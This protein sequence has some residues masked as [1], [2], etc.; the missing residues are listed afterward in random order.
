[1]IV[2]GIELERALR[3][4]LQVFGVAWMQSRFRALTRRAGTP[5][6]E[7]HTE[8][9]DRLVAPLVVAADG[10]DSSVRAAAGLSLR[11][12]DYDATGLVIHLNSSLAHQGTAL[13]WFAAHGVLAL[14][15]MPDTADGHQVSMVWSMPREQAAGL[16]AATE[17][18]RNTRLQSLLA[19][20][21]QERL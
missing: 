12:R 14:V 17:Q 3:A 2:E 4:A 6:I 9:G 15:P 7:L 8:S 18:D 11:R 16:L 20:A 10:S 5:D 13:Q 1:H 19:E 21:T